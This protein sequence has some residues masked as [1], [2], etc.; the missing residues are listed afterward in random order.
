MMKQ[1]KVKDSVISQ[2]AKEKLSGSGIRAPC[3]VTVVSSNG[4]VTISGSIQYEHQRP[5][6]LRAIGGVSGVQ[7]VV[8]QMRLIPSARQHQ[9]TNPRGSM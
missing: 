6:A 3:Q 5:I 7:R 8:D 2:K 4:Q 1:E 9:N